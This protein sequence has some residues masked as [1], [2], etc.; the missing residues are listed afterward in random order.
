MQKKTLVWV[1]VYIVAA[2]LI[3]WVIY[4]SYKSSSGTSPYQNSTPSDTTSSQSTTNTSGSSAAAPSTPTIKAGIVKKYVTVLAA[5]NSG[6]SLRCTNP[7][8]TVTTTYWIA[9][10]DVRR[11]IVAVS[12]T[13][14][15]VATP[16]TLFAWIKGVNKVTDYYGTVAAS[17]RNSLMNTSLIGVSCVT[18]NISSSTFARP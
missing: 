3:Y 13:N 14:Y 6:Y 10:G 15:L 8:G 4:A 11:D 17:E 9:R 7:S 1:I 18:A 2:A 5:L 16:S 12:G